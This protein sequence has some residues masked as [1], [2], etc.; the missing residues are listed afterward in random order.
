MTLKGLAAPITQNGYGITGTLTPT[1][2]ID[3]STP[4]AANA[5]AVLA[6]LL[7]DLKQRGYLE[8]G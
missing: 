6:T 1:R 2:T 8:N 5:A 3:V 7:D 4:T